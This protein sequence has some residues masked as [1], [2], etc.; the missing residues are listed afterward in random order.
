MSVLLLVLLLGLST[1]HLGLL[2]WSICK[3]LL[4]TDVPSALKHPLKFRILHCMFIYV[5]TL[6]NILEKLSICSMLSFLRF[7]QNRLVQKT[8]NPKVVVTDLHFG[9]IPVRL[10]EP[11]TMSCSP[12]RGIIFYH[13]GGGV[14]GSLDSYHNLCL[15]LALETNSVLLS[16]GYRKLPYY[17]YPVI[18][19]DCLN[20]TIHFLK[21]LK[22]YGVDPSQVLVCGESVGGGAAALVTQALVGHKDLPQIRAQVLIYPVIQGNNFQL[23]STQQNQNIPFLNLDFLITCICKYMAI[24]IS[25]KDAMLKGYCIPPETWE[26]YRKWLSSDNIPERFKNTYQEPQFPGTLNEAAYLETKHMLDVQN[27]PLLADDETIAQ[28]P[29]AFLVSC[30][31][32]ILRDDTLLYKKRLEDQGVPVSWH[33]VEDGFHGC[34]LLFDWKSFSFPCSEKILNAVVSYIKAL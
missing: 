16:V 32:D 1:F 11:K 23:P 7:V 20:A 6:G 29:E 28:L 26:K 8:K 19:S 25:W 12:R 21:R 4:T 24:D 2:V 27:S 33:N 34:I 14:L 17:H 15:F 31:H 18:A 9:T 13:G 22:T 3:H 10:F 30:E 5:I